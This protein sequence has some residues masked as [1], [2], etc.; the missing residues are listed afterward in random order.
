MSVIGPKEQMMKMY[1][2][3]SFIAREKVEIWTRLYSFFV[4]GKRTDKCSLCHLALI[5]DH[6]FN[7]YGRKRGRNWHSWYERNLNCDNRH[8][9][10]KPWRLCMSVRQDNRHPYPFSFS[11]ATASTLM[12]YVPLNFL[13][14]MSL[15]NGLF[16]DV[17]LGSRKTFT[18][19]NPSGLE[20]RMKE[21]SRN[22]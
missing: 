7:Y 4:K 1:G 17:W 12:I 18:L 21:S 16:W 15:S 5:C 19:W 8:F 9:L 11:C 10:H 14:L 20:P 2:S 22:E 3:Y 13:C 6:H